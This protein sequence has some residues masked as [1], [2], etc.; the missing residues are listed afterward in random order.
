MLDPPEPVMELGIL[1]LGLMF[2]GVFLLGG[3]IRPVGVIVAFFL[4]AAAETAELTGPVP[5]DAA[6][7]GTR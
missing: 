7:A 1:M 3:I 2:L 5:L 6:A 4:E